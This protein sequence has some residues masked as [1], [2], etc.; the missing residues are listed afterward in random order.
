MQ[1]ICMYH[2]HDNVPPLSNRLPGIRKERGQEVSSEERMELSGTE[3]SK[4][5]PRPG[6]HK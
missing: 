1:F 3:E 4:T 5:L 2:P 6:Q